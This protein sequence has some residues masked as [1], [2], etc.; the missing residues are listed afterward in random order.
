LYYFNNTNSTINF[1]ES[2]AQTAATGAEGGYY[3]MGVSYYFV[4]SAGGAKILTI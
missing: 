2:L 3:E 4:S 1:I